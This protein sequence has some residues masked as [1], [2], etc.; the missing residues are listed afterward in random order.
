MDEIFRFRKYL[1]Y[2]WK[3]KSKYYLHSPFVYQFY[4]N[5]IEGVDNTL[6][7]DKQEK[8]L[9]RL[10]EYF[11]QQNILALGDFNFPAVNPEVKIYSIH[12]PSGIIQWKNYPLPDLIFFNGNF[13]KEI[14]LQYFH[15]SLSHKHENSI[16]IFSNI[17][18]NKEM[19]DV[20]NEI[21]KHLEVTLTID[22]FQFGICFFRKD[23]L[24]K[25]NFVLRY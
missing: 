22:L 6:A 20:W 3:A 17:Y 13:S 16:F 18:Q 10:T 25:E 1:E 2:Q 9:Y 19:N 11:Q 5:I 21:K 14:I 4:L 8:F 15:Q 7:K 23:K 24:A 12:N